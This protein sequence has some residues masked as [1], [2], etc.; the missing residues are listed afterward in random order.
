MK[1]EFEGFN[2]KEDI[3]S[4]NKFLKMKMMLER[5]AHIGGSDDIDPELENA[6]LRNVI[7]FE[8]QF[9]ANKKIKV[10]DKIERPTIF[11]PVA[12]VSDEEIDS[13]LDSLLDW[14]SEYGIEV[15]LFSPNISQHEFYR[16]ITE[17]LFEYEMDD[18]SLPGWISNFCYDEF[19]PDPVYETSTKA[20]E[21]CIGPILNKTAFEWLCFFQSENIRFNEH[22]PLTEEQFKN[23]VNNFKEAY[24]DIKC[25]DI[26]GIKCEVNGNTSIVTGNYSVELS[27]A[28]QQQLITGKWLVGFESPD[29]YCWYINNV[30]IEGINF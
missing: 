20:E 10:Y 21:E 25:N 6:F 2:D 28:G 9:D 30:Q 5:G 11:K 1:K 16:F 14:L 3:K 22:Y 29:D 23:Y 17:E 18:I 19:H 27:L 13:A 12:D 7:A 15:S 4:E 26:S 8:E 24:D